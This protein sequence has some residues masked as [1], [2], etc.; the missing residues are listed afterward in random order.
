MAEEDFEIDVY[1]DA[2]DG[3]GQDEAHGQGADDYTQDEHQPQ[4]H[5]EVREDNHEM[6][7]SDQNGNG[8][9]GQRDDGV[10]SASP[11]PQQGTKRKQSEDLPVDHDATNAVQ[12]S[13]LQWYDTEDEIRTWAR[14]AACE[15]ALKE[16]TFSEHKVNGKSKGYVLA[17][18][19]RDLC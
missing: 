3:R 17:T 11:A 6:D 19:V 5:D 2:E 10:G 15:D 4:Q 14:V 1:G 9:D 12:L 13:E 8:I 7:G 18:S 16:I